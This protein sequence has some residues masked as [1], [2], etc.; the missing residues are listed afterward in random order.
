MS[1]IRKVIIVTLS[2][3]ALCS[4][5]GM[6]VDGLKHSRGYTDADIAEIHKY[7]DEYKLWISAGNMQSNQFNSQP[8]EKALDR[9]RAIYC[10]CIRK[11]G[12]EKCGRSGHKLTGADRVTW[13]KGNAAEMAIKTSYVQGNTVDAAECE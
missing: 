13:S 4:C 5:A 1:Q 11:L 3:A 12:V 8:R 7:M 2:L 10:S 6:A 9:V